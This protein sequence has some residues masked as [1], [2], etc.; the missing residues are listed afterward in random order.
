MNIFGL[1]FDSIRTHGIWTYLDPQ[2]SVAIIA[3]SPNNEEHC[4][5]VRK[6]NPEILSSAES[7]YEV[8]I[9]QFGSTIST[10]IDISRKYSVF[11]DVSLVPDGPKPLVLAMSLVPYY[12]DTKGIYCW[13]VGHVKP[14]EY[15]PIDIKPS[16]EYFGFSIRDSLYE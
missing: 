12:L 5:R 7:V 4:K 9:D 8:D 14:E 2:I 13:H 10:I 1:G 16:G 11:G 15:E 3:R 6:E